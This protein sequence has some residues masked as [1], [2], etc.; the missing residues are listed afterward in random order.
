MV[1]RN[2][3]IRLI[4]KYIKNKKNIKTKIKLWYYK[5][6]YYEDECKSK[7]WIKTIKITLSL[8]V[9]Y[10][11]KSASRSSFIA[12]GHLPVISRIEF[13]PTAITS[14]LFRSVMK[15]SAIVLSTGSTVSGGVSSCEETAANHKILVTSLWCGFKNLSRNEW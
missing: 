4:K 9:L 5:W 10:S 12:N 2:I 8:Y 13:M 7:E 11:I 6:V 14:L 1:I 15:L 3:K